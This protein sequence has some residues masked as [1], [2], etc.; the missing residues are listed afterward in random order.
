MKRVVKG[1]S[2]VLAS[3]LAVNIMSDEQEF[4]SYRRKSIKKAND[5]QGTAEKG[6]EGQLY[7]FLEAN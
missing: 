4:H 5:V 2:D 3:L 6:E 1:S 7:S